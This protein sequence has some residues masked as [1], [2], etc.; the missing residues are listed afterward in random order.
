M[1][2]TENKTQLRLAGAGALPEL[3]KIRFRTYTYNLESFYI[4]L[5]YSGKYENIYLNAPPTAYIF[6]RQIKYLFCISE[7]ILGSKIYLAE[8]VGTRL[9]KAG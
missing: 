1:R 9:D 7:N 4:I 5:L 6:L 2:N 8:K 3:G